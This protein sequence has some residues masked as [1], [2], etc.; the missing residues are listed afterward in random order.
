MANHDT[1]KSISTT[2]A[3]ASP[4]VNLRELLNLTKARTAKN[5]PEALSGRSNHDKASL[6]VSNISHLVDFGYH[7]Q[8]LTS[9]IK[10]TNG[11]GQRHRENLAARDV[12]L[13]GNIIAARDF[14]S[15]DKMNT[16]RRSERVRASRLSDRP[17]TEEHRMMQTNQDQPYA[18]MSVEKP[19]PHHS[20]QA[21]LLYEYDNKY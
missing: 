12:G 9:H 5:P 8:L 16:T 15:A 13:T 1:E 3:S 2:N 14:E 17:G 21:H 11:E 18:R 6:M 20:M 7:P 10:A 19:P 4:K